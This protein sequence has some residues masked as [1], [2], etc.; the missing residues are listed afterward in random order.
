M[1]N[2]VMNKL[3]L[4]GKEAGRVAD[5]ILSRDK[6]TGKEYMDF[7]NIDRMPDSLNCVCG[8]CTAPAAE[9]YLALLNPDE[10][11][12]DV[13][14][15]KLTKT[16]YKKLLAKVNTCYGEK[17][18][19]GTNEFGV[20]SE[21]FDTLGGKE[22][23]IR[24]GMQIVENRAKYG[25]STWYEWS[26]DHWGVKWNASSSRVERDLDQVIIYFETPWEDVAQLMVKIGNSAPE[27]DIEYDCSEEQIGYYEKKLKMN[28]GKI[29]GGYYYDP[30]SKEAMKHGIELWEVEDCYRYNPE[31]DNYES[32]WDD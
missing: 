13:S 9:Y 19:S 4:T 10:K 16:E 14:V 30:E 26:R 11:I 20:M 22:Q 5:K 8:S 15:K 2:W 3:V 25:H 17:K 6:E 27:I 24:Y 29:I 31:T 28:K 1:P 7:N 32:K 12:G 18:L 21:D 23:Y